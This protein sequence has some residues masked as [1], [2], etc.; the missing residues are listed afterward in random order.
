MGGKYAVAR[1]ALRS[2][3]NGVH[4]GKPC[5][6]PTG[7]SQ[8]QPNGRDW[9]SSVSRREGRTSCVGPHFFNAAIG[10]AIGFD[11]IPPSSLRASPDDSS[12]LLANFHQPTGF[13]EFLGGLSLPGFLGF[14]RSPNPRPRVQT[15]VPG[16]LDQLNVHTYGLQPFD[17]LFSRSVFGGENN[18]FLFAVFE[19]SVFEVPS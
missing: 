13:L 14:G 2:P 15:H 11:P 19:F 5:P 8:S 1:H 17:Y 6:E 12:G 3:P 9:A 4:F 7:F 16:G 18:C 10:E